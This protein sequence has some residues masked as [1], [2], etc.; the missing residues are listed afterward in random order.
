MSRQSPNSR[1]ASS[2]SIRS[3]A[4]SSGPQTVPIPPTTIIDNRNSS[5]EIENTIGPTAAKLTA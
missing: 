2:D 3:A 1:I 5:I 4:P